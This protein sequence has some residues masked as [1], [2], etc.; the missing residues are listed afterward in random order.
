M[1]D[2]LSKKI[3]NYMQTAS[4]S[5]SDTYYDFDEDLDAIASAVST[6]GESARA[7]VRYLQEL[8]YIKFAYNRSGDIAI[9]F[10]LDHKGLHYREFRWIATKE[11]WKRSVLT[12]II[13]T[14]LTTIFLNHLWPTIWRW[15][16]LLLISIQ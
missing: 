3:L 14:V 11:F 5:P 9:R 12:P 7:A 16:R 10:Y 1:L 6:D 15:L 13:V 8:G 4:S 2:K